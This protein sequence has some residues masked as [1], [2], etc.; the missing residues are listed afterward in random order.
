MK[1]KNRDLIQGIE[2]KGI[3]IMKGNRSRTAVQQAAGREGG[4]QEETDGI[5]DMLHCMEK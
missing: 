4:F 5:P 1:N 2:P 3:P